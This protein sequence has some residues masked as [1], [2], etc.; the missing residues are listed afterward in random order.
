MIFRGNYPHRHFNLAFKACMPA[1]NIVFGFIAPLGTLTAFFLEQDA[2]YYLLSSLFPE[3]NRIL[4]IFTSILRLFLL[5]PT[6]IEISRGIANIFSWA[7]IQMESVLR[8]QQ[9]FIHRVHSNF[10]FFW[11]QQA[12]SKILYG[13]IFPVVY[14]STYYVVVATFWTTVAI[15]WM[16]VRG[17]NRMP[18]FLGLLLKAG[19]VFLIVVHISIL[20][21]VTVL[22]SSCEEAILL[23][24]RRA[25]MMIVNADA[26]ARGNRRNV[27]IA[28]KQAK[29]LVPLRFKCGPFFVIGKEFIVMH[30]SLLFS[31][32]VDSIL[33]F[34]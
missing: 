24:R 16:A 20:P 6:L 11:E 12:R 21:N 27:R 31:R 29:A 32:T 10:P 28:M 30:L 5:I 15:C 19:A 23:Q 2:G 18:T 22:T 4:Q 9:I 8:I 25:G 26:N 13:M 17:A 33:I 3:Q 14:H 7:F 34:K 1:M